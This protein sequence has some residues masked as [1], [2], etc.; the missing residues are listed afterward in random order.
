LNQYSTQCAPGSLATCSGTDNNGN[1]TSQDVFI[2]HDDAV[3]ASTAWY[4]KFDYDQLN[5][6]QR[7]KE[8]N[9]ANSQLWQQEY[10]YD[11]WGNR[12]L[13]QTNT[14]GTGINKTELAFDTTNNNNRLVVP[15][16]ISGTIAYDSAGN[17]TT[18]TLHGLR[19]PHL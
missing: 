10:S 13:H 8:Y 7:V 1:L 3:S 17:L 18:D 14:W 19:Q 15:A 6:L 5:R 4:Q 16:G 11:R 12:G 2:P 9:S